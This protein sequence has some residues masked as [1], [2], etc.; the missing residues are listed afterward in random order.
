MGRVTKLNKKSLKNKIDRLV[1]WNWPSGFSKELISKVVNIHVFSL[2]SNYLSLKRGLTLYLNKRKTP[3]VLVEFYASSLLFQIAAWIC[4][5]YL[6][7][8]EIHSHERIFYNSIVKVKVCIHV[9]TKYKAGQLDGLTAGGLKLS[10]IWF[11]LHL[12]LIQ[13]SKREGGIWISI[14]WNKVS[15]TYM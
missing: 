4:H 5:W 14:N 8:K 1:G 7:T 13:T 2:C 10:W 3:Y 12:I 11:T 9:H 6:C 15:Y